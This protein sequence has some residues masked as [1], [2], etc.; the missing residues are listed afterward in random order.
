MK[1]KDWLILLLIPVICF[2]IYSTAYEKGITKQLRKELKQQAKEVME[3]ID[4]KDTKITGLESVIKERDKKLVDIDNRLSGL[5]DDIKRWK[6]DAIYWKDKA[7]RAAPEEL[8]ADVR[9]I[10]NT[11]EVWQVPEGILF[12]IDAFRQV[13][14]KLYDWKD[15]TEKREPAYL[16]GLELYKTKVFILTDDVGDLKKIIL[17]WSEKFDVQESFNNN[18]MKYLKRQNKKGWW[19]GIKQVGVGVALGAVTVFVLKDLMVKE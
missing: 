2:G 18:L 4:A 7:D 12:S 15:F 13:S 3:V 5:N 1:V 16:K 9:K 11:D 8:V 19:T 6:E 17:N 14:L 10:L